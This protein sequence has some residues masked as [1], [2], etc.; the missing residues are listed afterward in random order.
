MFLAIR[1]AGACPMSDRAQTVSVGG[2]ISNPRLH[3]CVTVCTLLVAGGWVFAEGSRPARSTIP[4]LQETPVRQYRAFR[5]MHAANER[6]NQ[7]GWVDCWTE[8][9]E[10]GFR[11]EIVSERG[12]DYVREKVL[13]TL[14]HREQELIAAGNAGRAEINGEN[15]EFAEGADAQD[16]Q[17]GERTVLLKPKR[18][19]VLL[20]DGRMVIN[21]E[22]TELLRV[23]GRLSK[24]PSFWTSLVNVIRHYARVDGVRV[25]I[26]TESTAKVKFA[27]LSYLDVHYEYETINGRPVNMAARRTVE[28]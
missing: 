14:L 20:V 15:Y 8:L 3:L 2:C 10:R 5:R 9:D 22:G 27:G 23:E 16:P 19:D 25:P 11:Y 12:S 26:A 28:D 6:F 13:K 1:R 4:A 7:E 24:N 17:G 21:Q 18:K